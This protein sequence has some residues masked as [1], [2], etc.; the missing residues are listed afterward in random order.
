MNCPKCHGE[1]IEAAH[2]GLQM[3]MD[4]C[5]YDLRC[6]DCE[7]TWRRE[8][9]LRMRPGKREQ[10]EW[11]NVVHVPNAFEREQEAERAKID[12]G[13]CPSCGA[14]LV[15]GAGEDM[16]HLCRQRFACAAACGF[17]MERISRKED[18]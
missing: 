5:A 3:A 6:L 1:R 14:A 17:R 11:A 12:R 16:G 2:C 10:S 15:E 8:R 13:E 18:A 9:G 4:V 7:H